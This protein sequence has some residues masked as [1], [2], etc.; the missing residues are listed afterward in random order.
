M[1]TTT[2]R[3]MQWPKRVRD[4]LVET[5]LRRRN[6]FAQP[7]RNDGHAIFV[8]I[9]I[10]SMLCVLCHGSSIAPSVIQLHAPN[11]EK[12]RHAC[13][14]TLPPPPSTP[15]P[16]LTCSIIYNRNNDAVNHHTTFAV[17]TPYETLKVRLECGHCPLGCYVERPLGIRLLQREYL[18]GYHLRSN[19]RWQRHPCTCR[20]L[21]TLAWRC[22][23]GESAM[24]WQ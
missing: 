23:S 7:R 17:R 22:Y 20:R 12:G 18:R 3:T 2:K 13:T 24:S 4:I 10:H 19:L 6:D 1:G 9:H 21:S 8:V 15:L 14:R 16:H 5:L 11:H